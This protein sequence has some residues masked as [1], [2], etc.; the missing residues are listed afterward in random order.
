MVREVQYGRLVCYGPEL[1]IQYVVVIPYVRYGYIDIAGI[2]FLI[3]R[4]GVC[5]RHGVS[6]IFHTRNPDFACHS[7][8]S[9]M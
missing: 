4:A 9:A 6:R 8:R 2:V 1:Y 5:K 3:M 7:L